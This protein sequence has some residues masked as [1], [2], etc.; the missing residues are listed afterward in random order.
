M[1]LVKNIQFSSFCEHHILPFFGNVSIAYIP[2]SESVV[3]LSKLA[4]IVDNY[5][6]RLQI[7]E[8][9]TQ[10]N[11]GAFVIVSAEHMCMSVR[12]IMKPGSKTIT[13]AFSGKF[14]IDRNLIIETQQLIFDTK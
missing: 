2:S 7:Q 5:A 3:G 1:V 9:M 12:G 13:R 14:E 6:K 10:Q 8:R 4:R 11:D